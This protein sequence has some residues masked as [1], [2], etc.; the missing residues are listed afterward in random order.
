MKNVITALALI[1]LTSI[2]TAK[3]VIFIGSP[4][5]TN[6]DAI[7]IQRV[8]MNA[9]FISSYFQNTG[10]FY[11]NTTSGNA[12]G[13]EWPKTSGKMACF[14][15]GLCIGC[16]I[17]GQYAQVMA[18]YRGE[19][20]PGHF[21][22]DHTWE[23]NAD[24]KM[25]SVKAGD[26]I[27]N[28]PDYANWYKIVPY[29]APYKDVNNNHQFDIGIDIPGM[30]NSDQ[31]IFECM[32]DGDILQ[33]S[34]NEGFGGGITSPLLGAE[35]HFTAWSYNTPP[36]VDV[37]FMSW[38]VINKGTVKWDS[39]FMG[40][41]ADPDL[42]DPNDDYIGCDTALNLGFCYNADNM[43]G[44]G[45]APTY[46][47]NPPAFGM[48]YF[49]SPINRIT[50]DT[51]GLTSF[52]FFSDAGSSPPPCE[53]DPN[54]E[55]VPAYHLLQGMKK[56]RTPFMDITK[57]PPQKSKY[58]YYGKPEIQFGWVEAK[59]S[60]QNCN[61]DTT[62]FIIP[63][64]PP[65]DRRFVLN[66]GALDFSIYPGDTQNVVVSGLIARSANHLLAVNAV[67]TLNNIAK[68][69]YDSIVTVSVNN[70]G[71]EIPVKYNLSQNYPNPF[72]PRTVISV[73]LPAAGEVSLKVYDVMGREVQTLVKERLNAGTYNVYFD[74]SG[75]T[76]GVY[77]YKMTA[78][79]YTETKRMLLIK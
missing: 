42:G 57:T 36:L 18:S 19:Y 75:L 24:F 17:N 26:N 32:G 70:I 28:N 51:L 31:T 16:G 9:N 73:Q 50:G 40:I 13:F 54:G 52:V 39:T 59:G 55:P 27:Y 74:G 56:D 64:N 14:T 2:V 44:T 43:D 79:N 37:Q 5:A 63:S 25:Y 49:R 7:V 68:K 1:F 48:G 23:T 76:S 78:G 41:V 45:S 33:R 29:G 72:N 10:I 77:F 58:V 3:P 62:G 67:K 34:A 35:I 8:I 65:G 20:A 15:A 12:P 21:K 71:T 69:A 22:P 60:M 30:P 46:G 38:K 11:Q 61:G 53:S 4:Y 6:P 66:S 47:N